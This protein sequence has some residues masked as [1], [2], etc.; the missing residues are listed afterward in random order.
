MATPPLSPRSMKIAI[1]L[2][3]RPEIIKL[4]PVIRQCQKSNI[5]FF[6]IHSNQHYSP[7]MDK[8]FFSELKLPQPK[9]NLNVGSGLH[10]EMT[11]KILVVLKKFCLRS[12]LIGFWFKVIPILFWP[13][14]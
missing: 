5:D 8:I 14:L 12:F 3:T 9:Y 2:G 1:I 4:S 11:A 10:G 6:I 13:A 7:E